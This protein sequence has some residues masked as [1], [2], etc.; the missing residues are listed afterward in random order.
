MESACET[1][2]YFR[3][4]TE[5]LPILTRQPDHARNHGQTERAALFIELIKRVDAQEQTS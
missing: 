1:C 3:T 5:F 2:A 4:S